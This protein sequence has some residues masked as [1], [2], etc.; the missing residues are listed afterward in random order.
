MQVNAFAK[1]MSASLADQSRWAITLGE[2]G[3]VFRGG[4]LVG[5]GVADCGF[6]I[7]DLIAAAKHFP[8]GATVLT[9][10][11]ERLPKDK[12]KGNEAAVLLIKNGLNLMMGDAKYADFHAEGN[13]YYDVSTCGIGLHGDRE[14]KKV[15]CMVVVICTSPGI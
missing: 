15:V 1:L 9:L 6:T 2:Q 13:H 5:N 4:T 3:E 7:A 14:R 12:Q 10:L 11:H 8:A